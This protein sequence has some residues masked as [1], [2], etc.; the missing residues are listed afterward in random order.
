M[1]YGRAA[2][3][4]LVIGGTRFVGYQ[5]VWRLIA[6][7]HRV[8]VFN[9]GRSPDPFGDRVER[10]L[11][12]RTTPAL[13]AL[14][15]GR[16][17]DATVDFAA[18][19]AADVAPLVGEPGCGHYVFISTGQVYLVREGCSWPASEED[20]DGPVS[21]EPADAT[22]RESWL[23]GVHKREAEDVLA[24]AWRTS[25]FPSTRLR[26]PMVNGERD[27]F[28]RIESY[29]WRLLDGGPVL[30]PDGGTYPVRHV[31]SGDVVQL[32]E[33]LLGKP[34]THGQAYNLAQD[35]SPSLADLIA[36][37][38]H[39]LGAPVRLVPVSR[40]AL[41]EAGLDPVAVSPFSDP[42]MS[43][44]D[45]SRAKAVLGFRPEPLARSLDKIVAA[46]LNHPPPAPPDG[47]A[48]RADEVA[49][50]ARL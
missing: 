17:F 10:V 37:L 48:R 16:R 8:T 36:F 42:W 46:F 26:L 3:D 6:A 13:P 19:S 2:V 35:E 29:L 23:Y 44:L 18:Y 41:H 49:L 1:P 45:A 50:A 15:R 47:Y 28:R 7:R 21:P 11:G 30:L 25:R 4:V 40:A 43:Q 20:Y 14:L 12:D 34:A 5:L 39:L 27:H 24:A 31:Y 32:I 33:R 38:A 22:G 9:R